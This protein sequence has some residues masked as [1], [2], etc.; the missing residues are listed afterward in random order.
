MIC[1]S[2]FRLC[3]DF[4]VYMPMVLVYPVRTL[5]IELSLQIFQLPPEAMRRCNKESG[6][7]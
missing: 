3:F 5:G 7:R 2:A 1:L 4:A 6:F